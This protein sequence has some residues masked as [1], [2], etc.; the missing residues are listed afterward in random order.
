MAAHDRDLQKT[1]YFRLA[2]QGR[3]MDAPPERR[4]S[5]RPSALPA[6]IGSPAPGPLR[7]AAPTSTRRAM[8]P[9][10][11][12]QPSA[13]IFPACLPPQPSSQ[14][15]NQFHRPFADGL[16]SHAGAGGARNQALTYPADLNRISAASS[17]G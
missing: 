1:P 10:P 17:V 5:P 13:S 12:H 16:L 2:F 7:R 4:R 14:A 15:N 6:S 11:Q 9:V 3:S 8:P